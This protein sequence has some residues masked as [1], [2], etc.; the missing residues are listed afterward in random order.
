MF[1]LSDYIR[2]VLFPVCH[3]TNVPT[4]STNV[5]PEV[6]TFSFITVT[7][8]CPPPPPHAAVPHGDAG[9][10][11]RGAAC[12]Q[13]MSQLEQSDLKAPPPTAGL[14]RS[15]QLNTRGRSLYHC[16]KPILKITQQS[17]QHRVESGSSVKSKC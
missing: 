10:H 17:F 3:F 11:H 9:L 1:S 7:P 15:Q 4:S 5:P 12:H 16:R 14:T 2:S 6:D 13:S 8:V